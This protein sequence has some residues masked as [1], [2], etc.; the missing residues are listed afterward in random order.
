VKQTGA[1]TSTPLI[2]GLILIAA[3]GAA[4]AVARKKD[5]FTK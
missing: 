1:D 4:Y 2:A 3:L 5:L